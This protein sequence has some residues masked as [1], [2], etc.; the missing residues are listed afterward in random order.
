MGQTWPECD[1][2]RD[3]VYYGP[4]TVSNAG[5]RR[6]GRLRLTNTSYN[7]PGSEKLSPSRS[8]TLNVLRTHKVDLRGPIDWRVSEAGAV[9]ASSTRD[10]D[11]VCWHALLRF[12]SLLPWYPTTTSKCSFGRRNHTNPTYANIERLVH[13][14]PKRLQKTVV[15]NLVYHFFLSQLELWVA[16]VH[17]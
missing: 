12:H 4:W 11:S 16:T 17:G 10:N 1:S 5:C 6:G 8:N 9:S 14:N 2:F 13:E 3:Y 15:G 7:A